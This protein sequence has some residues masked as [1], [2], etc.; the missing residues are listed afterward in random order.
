MSFSEPNDYSQF[1]RL[2]SLRKLKLVLK[3]DC[4]LCFA[5]RKAE[6]GKKMIMLNEYII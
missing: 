1:V 4:R 3:V 5:L 2:V 6:R